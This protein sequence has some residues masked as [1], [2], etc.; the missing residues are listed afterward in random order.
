M[1]IK[2]KPRKGLLIRDPKTRNP[3][4]KE[5]AFVVLDT[6]WRRRLADGDVEKVETKKSK[7]KKK[8]IT[9]DNTK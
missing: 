9:D 1:K 6:F 4:P 8:E 2:I 5:G 7:N 3:I